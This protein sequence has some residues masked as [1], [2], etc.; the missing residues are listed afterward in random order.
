M[1][2]EVTAI[3]EVTKWPAGAWEL[4]AETDGGWVKGRGLGD[5]EGGKGQY[6]ENFVGGFGYIHL[7]HWYLRI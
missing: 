2:Y 3:R 5:A 6:C 1:T 7:F 4:G